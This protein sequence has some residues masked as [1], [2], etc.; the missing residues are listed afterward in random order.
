MQVHTWK[1]GAPSDLISWARSFFSITRW[2]PQPP[3]LVRKDDCKSSTQKCEKCETENRLHRRRW[4]VITRS[5]MTSIPQRCSP[6]LS[7]QSSEDQVEPEQPR[8]DAQRCP[9]H[10]AQ[11][12]LTMTHNHGRECW[13]QPHSYSMEQSYLS[14]QDWL[15]LLKSILIIEGVCF[16]FWRSGK[17]AQCGLRHVWFFASPWT[18]AHQAPV[19]GISQARI[20]AWVAISYYRVSFQPRDWTHFSC[21]S[22]IGRRI[23]Y[24]CATWE[25]QFWCPFK[26]NKILT[27]VTF[28]DGSEKDC[29][30][31]PFM[32]FTI[33]FFPQV[34]RKNW[35]EFTIAS[36]HE[37][38]ECSY[39]RLKTFSSEILWTSISAISASLNKMLTVNV[40]FSK[41]E[42]AF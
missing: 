35:P 9:Q 27:A 11:T 31:I 14:H 12:Q 39:C 3:A 17:S 29:W 22:C 30:H 40:L 19:Y 24:N 32:C 21:I 41:V 38:V 4:P 37:S 20:L 1:P 36:K 6:G 25:A 28:T 42:C 15:Y 8:D 34:W 10:R 13:P 26:L 23:L 33:T 5:G 16:P 7:T 2:R 18:A